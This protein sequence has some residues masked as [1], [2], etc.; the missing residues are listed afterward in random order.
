MADQRWTALL[1]LCGDTPAMAASIKAD[2]AEVRAATLSPN[3]SVAMFVDLPLSHEPHGA[4]RSLLRAD[5]TPDDEELGQ[6]DSGSTATFRD[7]LLW[8]IREL[9]AEHYVLV[10]GGTGMLDPNSVVG[11][12]ENNWTDVFA[13]CDDATAGSGMDIA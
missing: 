5:A 2:A 9:P 7:F 4:V 1:Y 12:P 10:I 11:H 6:I 3:L 8:G 13:I